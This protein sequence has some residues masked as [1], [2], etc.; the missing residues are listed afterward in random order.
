M[1]R[2]VIRQTISTRREFRTF[3]E[4]LGDRSWRD[5]LNYV[6]RI[7]LKAADLLLC[8]VNSCTITATKWTEYGYVGQNGID[9][10]RQ[11]AR[12][13]INR[14]T[15][16]F[17]V[18]HHH[19]LPVAQV[20]APQSKGVTLA[21][22]ASEILSESQRSGV[23]IILHGHQHKPKIAIYQDLPLSGEAAGCPIHVIANGSAGAKNDRLPYGE[24]NSYCLFRLNVE[25]AELWMRE[26]RLDGQQGAQLF[27]GKPSSPIHSRCD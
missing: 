16:R 11:L 13:K 19:L 2:L 3:V 18:L 1:L 12:E 23:Q 20:E 15:F 6:R 22:D 27:C 17:L 7:R 21:L 4:E 25:E 26:L 8:V 24:R 9:A 5:T 10:L 14:P